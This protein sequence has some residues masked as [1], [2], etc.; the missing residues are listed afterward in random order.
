MAPVRV[1]GS[2][3]APS[4]SHATASEP[5]SEA[6]S[7]L[8]ASSAAEL[9]EESENQ[10]S[11]DNSPRISANS[12]NSSNSRS[13]PIPVEINEHVEKWIT[14]FTKKDRERFQRFLDRGMLY[15]DVVENTLEENDLPAELYYLAMIESGY[16][17]SAH[18][19]ASAVGVWQFIQGTG[20]RYGLRIDQ[21]IDE[22]RDPIRATEAA[23]KY[24]RD[25][26]NVF[27]S[28]YLAMAAYNSGEMR[29]LRAV[30]K[31]GTRDFWELHKKKALPSETRDYVP[32][33]LA[34]VLIGQNPEKY[35]FRVRDTGETY[36][37]LE[38]TEVPPRLPL[39]TLAKQSGISLSTL[40]K[41][42][43]HIKGNAVPPG[44]SAY[45]IWIPQ[46]RATAVKGLYA[47]LEKMVP[48]PE[49]GSSRNVASVHRVR[50]GD[51][52]SRIAKKYKISVGHLKR[53][54]NLR[55]NKIMVGMKLRVSPKSYANSQVVRYK[56][57]RGDNLIVLAR[58]FNTTV[59]KIKSTNGLRKNRIYIGQVLK[60][61]PKHL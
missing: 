22:R 19:R 33:F 54:N 49:R 44:R 39:S 57:R 47:K 32:K 34:A 13:Y 6:E 46:E 16:V 43:P 5:E 14:Y 29:V 18:S 59:K 45:E 40:K 10:D 50:R 11:V 48:T 41:V 8:A 9:S 27:G 30:F 37:N 26:Y 12:A 42:N 36:P 20:K 60:I 56:V 2:P 55:S 24:L 52:L 21:Y 61:E 23:A 15:R 58:R 1:V 53:I 38:L 25:L 31:A 4:V 7:E 3:A 28:W 35:G 17:T 51:N